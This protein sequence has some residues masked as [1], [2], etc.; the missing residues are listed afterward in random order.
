MLTS[1]MSGRS[2]FPEMI[3]LAIAGLTTVM[4]VAIR[5]ARAAEPRPSCLR[6]NIARSL[7]DLA[8][9][10][11]LT[12]TAAR[13]RAVLGALRARRGAAIGAIVAWEARA[14][15]LEGFSGRMVRAVCS[16]CV[17]SSVNFLGQ[18]F[19]PAFFSPLSSL[20]RSNS[21]GAHRRSGG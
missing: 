17:E 2:C 16:A 15:M 19:S 6:E 4:S 10:D 18:T 1:A 20:V 3:F 7:S 21:W 9:G 13:R 11:A 8:S 5:E 14:N 12:R